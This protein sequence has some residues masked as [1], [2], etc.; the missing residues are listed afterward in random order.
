VVIDERRVRVPRHRGNGVE[1]AASSTDRA[2]IEWKVHVQRRE[3]PRLL[4]H[5]RPI[6]ALEPID[7]N[8]PVRKQLRGLR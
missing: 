4:D 5:V 7:M 2:R 1:V 6:G 3:R 8:P